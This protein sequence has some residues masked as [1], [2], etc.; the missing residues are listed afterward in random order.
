MDINGIFVDVPAWKWALS[1]LYTLG[2]TLLRY[3]GSKKWA[4]S[5]IRLSV[6]A[7]LCFLL[8]EPLLKSTTSEIEPS[9]IVLVY[10]ASSSQWIGN[11]SIPRKEVLNSWANEGEKLFREL[12]YNVEVWDFSKQLT[13]RKK[14]ECNGL[15]TDLSSA[16]EGIKNKYTHRNVRGVVITTD[17]LSNSGRDPEFGTSTLDVPHFF[18]GTGDTTTIRDI[19]INQLLC[20]QVTYLNNEF[21]LEI[22][23][24]TRTRN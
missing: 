3:Y 19:E 8:L 14:W 18:I 9:T 2:L 6:L 1:V 13:P 11:D 12:D 10:D 17:G 7:A 4:L 24:R 22:R 16:L 23:I 21:P 15:R 20:N 5:A